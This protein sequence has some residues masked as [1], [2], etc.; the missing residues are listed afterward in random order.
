MFY[1]LGLIGMAMRTLFDRVYYSLQDTKTP[2]I[3][4][5]IAIGFNIVLNLI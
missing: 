4:G 2:L 1:T 3:N 5:A